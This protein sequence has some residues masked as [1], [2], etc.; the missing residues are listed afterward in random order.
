MCFIV[1]AFSRTIV[2]WRV[3]GHMRTTMVLDAIEMSRWSRGTKLAG[4]RCQSDAGSQFMWVRYG[5]LL[6]GRADPRSSTAAAME[7]H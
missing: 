4:L 6:P 1:D 7:D 2:G 5:E 3:A